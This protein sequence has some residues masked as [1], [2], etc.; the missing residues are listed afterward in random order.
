MEN[1][2]YFFSSLTHELRNAINGILG[3]CH[4]LS[5]TKLNSEQQSYLG[6]LN[7]CSLQLLELLNDMLDFSKLISGHVEIN[8]ECVLTE[9][10]FR[11]VNV[12][13]ETKIME[14]NQQIRYIVD[15]NVPKYVVI[16]RKKIVHILINL[17]SNAN[18]YTADS[19]RIIVHVIEEGEDHNVHQHG[20]HTA[21]NSHKLTFSVEDT[22]IGIKE[23]DRQKIFAPFTQINPGNGTGLGLAICQKTTQILNGQ[24]WVES[25]L[26]VGSTFY[27]RVKYDT[28]QLYEESLIQKLDPIKGQF[29]LVVD[30]DLDHRLLL[31][32]I[33]FEYNIRPI[34]C[35]TG[36]EGL[37]LLQSARY[38]FIAALIDSAVK[39]IKC[40]VL[41][42][43]I[44]KNNIFLIGITSILDHKFDHVLQKPVNKIKL[45]DLL[46]KNVRRDTPEIE[47]HLPIESVTSGTNVTS[48]NNPAK[49]DLK[50]LIIEDLAYNAEILLKILTNYGFKNIETID[51][52]A[53]AI[54]KLDQN[55]YDIVFL[56]L[57]MPH[58]NGFDIL[59]HIRTNKYD[60][61][62]AV[63]TA[64]ILDEDKEKCRQLGANYFLLKP[65]SNNQLK[66]ILDKLI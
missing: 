21:D 6:N 51:N 57:K 9:D 52:G 44:K 59:T 42:Q 27:F 12:V 11:E 26:N 63:I 60:L 38:D 1:S 46:I 22:G 53:G 4:L 65:I 37:K 45:L 29:V 50:I 43:Q 30:T 40:D 33:L 14:K 28:P 10:I 64:S 17:V 48:S 66:C 13:L 5:V 41:I 24:I 3:Y 62:V 54:L 7:M 61:K 15:P 8:P 36:K 34:I 16:D 47:L 20:N 32:D 19:G 56:D 35:S 55:R 49:N 58:V 18:K 25:E 2:I 23:E 31:G 39:D